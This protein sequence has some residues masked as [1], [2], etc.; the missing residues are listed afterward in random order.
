MQ[1]QDPKEEL[2]RRQRAKLARLRLIQSSQ[3]NLPH[4]E[5]NP[6]TVIS[7]VL[8]QEYPDLSTDEAAE[9]AKEVILAPNFSTI[10]VGQKEVVVE[11]LQFQI[12]E[13]IELLNSETN[14]VQE[15]FSWF[16]DCTRII[17][18]MNDGYVSDAD[19]KERNDWMDNS[20]IREAELMTCLALYQSSSYREAPQKYNQIYNK[21]VKLRQL[22]N[23]IK[24]CTG[25]AS[26]ETRERIEEN[27]SIV[28]NP[29]DAAQYL[30]MFERFQHHNQ[31]WNMTRSELRRL[32]MFH[33][34]DE[35]LDG[36]YPYFYNRYEEEPQPEQSI[37]RSRF[38]FMKKLKEYALFHWNDEKASATYSHAEELQK[39]KQEEKSQNSQDIQTRIE[40]LRARRHGL[41]NVERRIKSFVAERFMA[42]SRSNTH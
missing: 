34:Y 27:I 10:K 30:M 25:N 35:D 23:A 37:K 4:I 28:I 26:D 11:D 1:N 9:V 12:A 36:E 8:K 6:R 40:K 5:S 16:E 2:A 21:L 22:R 32:H 31:Y 38:D 19:L 39:H 24:E 13:S 29:K 41:P 18:H 33:G 7:Q 17:N 3:Q 20:Y 15:Y 14:S 42:I